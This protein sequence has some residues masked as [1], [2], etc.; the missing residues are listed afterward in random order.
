MR[1]I[2]VHQVADEARFNR[3]HG[4]VLFWCALI[5][6]FDGYDLAVA[7]IALPSIIFVSSFFTVL[8]Q[9]STIGIVAVAVGMLM[10][11][12]EF[13]LSAGVIVTSA[14]LV[15]AMLCYQ[16][17]LNLWVGAALSLVVALAV[18][19]FN[20]YMVM[21]TKLPS[22]IVTLATIWP[23]AI[24]TDTGFRTI[25]ATTVAPMKAIVPLVTARAGCETSR[26]Q[27]TAARP[28]TQSPWNG[29]EPANV[30]PLSRATRIWPSSP[31]VKPRTGL[32]F[33]C[34]A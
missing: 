20:G 1:R 24:N 8:Y 12:G 5:I 2:D 27:T 10:I 22:F 23:V 21:T 26:C 32:P 34:Q 3:F 9:S 6:I 17:G 19:F 11:G 13:D 25:S 29:H 31:W 30:S 16:L 28:S 7:G 33:A 4:L 18:G 15:N 14:G